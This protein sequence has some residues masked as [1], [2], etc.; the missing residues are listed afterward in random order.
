[1]SAGAL[2]TGLSAAPTGCSGAATGIPTAGA[3]APTDA[4]YYSTVPYKLTQYAAF[5]EATY[6]VNDKLDITAGLRLA[7]YEE[8]RKLTFDGIFADTTIDFP[9]NV[10]A[11]DFAPRVIVSYKATDHVTL[12][13]QVSK[14]FRLGGV[15]DPL[16]KPLCS[17]A[18]LTT[19]GKLAKPAFENESV[20]NYEA[21]LKANCA[22]WL[23]KP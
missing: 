13:G 12:N 9:G 1:M 7:R 23:A 4:L 6:H 16:N 20:W 10:K 22:Y 17:A 8:K 3:R 5:G 2:T 21:G 15:N 11:D 18:D 14:G 19:F